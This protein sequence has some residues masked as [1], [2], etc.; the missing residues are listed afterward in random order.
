MWLF[1]RTASF[2]KAQRP[3]SSQALD[4]I[5]SRLVAP[6]PD[7]LESLWTTC[8]G[9]ELSYDLLARFD[10]V[11]EPLPFSFTE[12]FFPGS[13]HYRDLPGWMDYELRLAQ[14]AAEEREQS[15]PKKLEYLPFGGFEYLERIYV[16]LVPGT[17]HGSVWGWRKALP[18]GWKGA[19]KR[20]S[21]IRLADN[22]RSLWRM[23]HVAPQSVLDD[24]GCMS[25]FQNTLDSLRNAGE[26]A[27]ADRVR[28]V[29]A[30]TSVDS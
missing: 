8:F 9:G 28:A 12:L 17:D 2:S 25:T 6:L 3:I 19:L 29:Y 4:E 1:L 27:L 10:G 22:V 7:D 16:K 5:N 30:A 15:L 24:Y 20:D 26:S 18:P 13:D 11:D 23:L 14:E 21:V